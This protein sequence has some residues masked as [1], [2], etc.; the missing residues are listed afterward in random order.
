MCECVGSSAAGF[1][2]QPRRAGRRRSRLG[3][4]GRRPVNRGA[5]FPIA[6]RSPLRPSPGGPG[7]PARAGFAP[8]YP[9]GHRTTTRPRG[10]RSRTS[11][12]P[13]SLAETRVR[14]R[15]EAGASPR[16][17]QHAPAAP[18]TSRCSG[19]S[20]ATHASQRVLRD[21]G[22][23]LSRGQK[24]EVCCAPH[25]RSAAGGKRAAAIAASIDRSA[26]S[27]RAAQAGGTGVDGFAK[28]SAAKP[29]ARAALGGG[30][31]GG[32]ARAGGASGF[33][34]DGVSGA[35]T[36][37]PAA[38]P[39]PSRA[40]ASSA[41]P[42][43]FSSCGNLANTA[44]SAGPL[45]KV[46]DCHAPIKP[47]RVRPKIEAIGPPPLNLSSL[48]VRPRRGPSPPPHSVPP[49]VSLRLLCASWWRTRPWR[50]RASHAGGARGGGRKPARFVGVN[51]SEK[52][53]IVVFN[54]VCSSLLLTY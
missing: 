10:S 12:Y 40:A 53:D 15:E 35:S 2:N 45:R 9:A 46:A 28:S 3:A 44:S 54:R 34:G 14:S 26:S 21:A 36:S 24:G 6:P 49:R 51:G 19:V 43:L 39:S 18:N 20:R 25:H 42:S 8:P 48:L 30:G 11:L 13:T 7:P 22:A 16:P 32:V 31:G 37:S 4:P 41:L 47:N 52:D 33:V 17:S 5:T 1:G 29:V 38:A 50:R 27:D 23:G